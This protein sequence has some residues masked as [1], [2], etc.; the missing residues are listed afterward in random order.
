MIKLQFTSTTV[1]FLLFSLQSFFLKINAQIPPKTYVAYK[2]LGQ[3]N[4]D[5]KAE[6]PAWANSIWTDDFI[7]IEGKKIPKFRSRMKMSWDDD[8]LYFFVEMEESHIW[9]T[10]KQRDTVIFY[11]NDFE[12]FIDP[13]G[14]T[15]D[16]MEFEMNA[17]NT[18]WDLWL[19]KPYRNHPKVIDGWDIHGLKTA[20]HFNGTLNNASDTDKNWTVEIAM[21]W[22]ALVEANNNGEIPIDDF[23]RLNFSRVNWDFDV[24]NGRYSRKKDEAGKYLPEYNWVWSPQGVINMHEPEHW[25]YVYFSENK[26]GKFEI[27]KD[28]YLKRH[29]Y[30]L[31]RKIW[32][33]ENEDRSRP[34]IS[35]LQEIF[36]INGVSATPIFTEHSSGWNI[37]V[38]S[39]FSGSKLVLKDDGKFEKHDKK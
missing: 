7:D 21:P 34:A 26:N 15:H 20:V 33:A 39:P 8:N 2:A 19:T 30:N 29:L 35:E 18:T 9:G 10:L 12:I 4:I 24:I 11:N 22:E 32:K 14:D 31:A 5:G 17:L 25:G 36:L 37:S 27:P 1:L 38:R 23:W 6:E 3:I 13:D 16:Y 28:D